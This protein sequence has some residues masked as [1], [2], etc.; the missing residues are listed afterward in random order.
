MKSAILQSLLY[1][2]TQQPLIC[3]S[4]GVGQCVPTVNSIGQ[5]AG[6][7]DHK[8]I[9]EQRRQLIAAPENFNPS[10]SPSDRVTTPDPITPPAPTTSPTPP[11][12]QPLPKIAAPATPPS[13][14]PLRLTQ[15]DQIAAQRAWRYFEH[16]WNPQTGL[17]N[18]VDNLPWTTLWDQGSALLGI[19]A[20]RQLGL[21]APNL[22]R[23]RLN[24]L[25]Q[26]LETLPLPATG[27]PNKAY[28]TRTAEMRQLDDSPDPDGRSGWSA[29]DMARFLLGLHI[30]RSHYP[31][32]GD[33]INRIVAHWQISRL[34]RAG[35]LS[36]G[37]P[38]AGG[39]VHEVQEGRLGY[40][41]Y[42]AHSLKLWHLEAKKALY[43][44]P[45]TTIQLDGIALQVDQ[46]NLNNSGASNYLTSEPYVLWG[47]EMGW[48]DA[49]KPQVQ[50]LLKVQAQRFQH[51]GILT[52]VNEDSLDRPPY[53]LYYNVY[54]NGQPWQAINT[55]GRSYPQLR[56]LSTKAAFAWR[57]LMPNSYTK[58]LRDS[59][60]SLATPNRGYVSG[61]Y[62]DSHLGMNASIDVNTNAVVLE[63]LL[64]HARGGPLAF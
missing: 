47:L 43:H 41:Q 16:N 28:S 45:M 56:F 3:P 9:F 17:V 39:R 26:T 8:H 51:T 48:P 30:L 35:W 24:I 19:H 5:Q 53:F 15:A 6:P 59:I 2:T 58:R 57:A 29:L 20:A 55:Q 33:R 34:V 1:L 50:N 63:S 13:T 7:L 64:Y 60:Q 4:I 37:M 10:L 25:L 27:L 38:A 18:S 54:A 61:R 40:E 49:V 14:N 11:A 42:A 52:A 22:F 46:R 23:Q 21:L 44:P 36:G 62:E 32:Y 12:R 31:E